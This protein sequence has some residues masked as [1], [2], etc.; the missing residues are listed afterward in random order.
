MRV[1]LPHIASHCLRDLPRKADISRV[2]PGKRKDAPQMDI[3]CHWVRIRE[4]A[5]LADV[6]LHDLRHTYASRAL[7]LGEGLPMIGKLL[8]HGKIQTTARYAHL[9]WDSVNAAAARVA[10]SLRADI[11][12][13]T[14]A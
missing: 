4:R 10:K 2:F 1:P 12:G 14:R 3:N 11:E 8:G 5:G 6:R 9:P 13:P 7:E